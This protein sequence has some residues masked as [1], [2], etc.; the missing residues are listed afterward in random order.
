MEEIE[1]IYSEDKIRRIRNHNFEEAKVDFDNKD[2]YIMDKI[3]N[4]AVNF[5]FDVD[6]VY[7][8]IANSEDNELKELFIAVRLAKDPTR[9]NIYEK[10]FNKF[11]KENRNEFT[12]LKSQGKNAKYLTE[13]GLLKGNVPSGIDKTKSLDFFEKIGNTEYYYYHKYTKVTGGAQA[14]QHNDM[15][16]F[17]RLA[18]N[19]CQN[20]NDNINFVGVID[21]PY[22]VD[23]I[24]GEIESFAGE[25]LNSRIFVLTWREV[26]ST[27][28]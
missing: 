26:I 23:R 13:N 6:D 21:G 20:F 16:H 11:M 24:R 27:I 4:I 1:D 28:N 3:K 8:L 18:N 14:N 9:Q 5:G 10:S 17:I 15:V 19:Y 25:F 7:D 2:R 12:K 22:Y